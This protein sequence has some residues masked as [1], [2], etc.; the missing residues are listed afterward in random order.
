MDARD[1]VGEPAVGVGEPPPLPFDHRDR[2]C[3]GL[4]DL[5]ERAAGLGQGIDRL[6]ERLGDRRGSRRTAVAAGGIGPRQDLFHRVRGEG[7]RSSPAL[8]DLG[9]SDVRPRRRRPGR[10]QLQSDPVELA[11]D[12]PQRLIR[13]R[14]PVAALGHSRRQWQRAEQRGEHGTSVRGRRS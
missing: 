9:R 14:R 3:V 1:P 2:Q 10:D 8:D 7:R 6:A 12:R 13:P 4:V 5:D 11:E